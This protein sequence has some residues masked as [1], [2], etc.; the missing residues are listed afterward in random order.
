MIDLLFPLY[1]INDLISRFEYPQPSN[2]WDSPLFH[3]VYDQEHAHDLNNNSIQQYSFDSIPFDEILTC[4]V[5]GKI[6]PKNKAIAP[7]IEQ[8]NSD[9]Y[10]NELSSITENLIKSFISEQKLAL[11]GNTIKLCQ[12]TKYVTLYRKVTLPQLRAWRKIFISMMQKQP[13]S[14]SAIPN[15]FID[16]LNV[17]LSN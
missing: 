8:L 2:R 9:N 17:Q 10:L 16:Y 12:G 1:S 15:A 5:D 6:A 14:L 7:P 4:L 3:L 13:L 11:E